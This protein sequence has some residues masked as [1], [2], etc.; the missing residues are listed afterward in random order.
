MCFL[1]KTNTCGIKKQR[2]ARK[3]AADVCA[4]RWCGHGKS[5]D[6]TL[7]VPRHITTVSSTA[8]GFVEAGT[9]TGSKKSCQHFFSLSLQL[10]GAS[11]CEKYQPPLGEAHTCRCS[12]GL[13]DDLLPW[14]LCVLYQMIKQRCHMRACS[15]A[16]TRSSQGMQQDP[17]NLKEKQE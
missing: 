16:A 15:S 3:T 6:N 2:K 14:D 4:L 10:A 12:A 11:G 8:L 17:S 9:S 1:Y 7:L 13:Q 5:H